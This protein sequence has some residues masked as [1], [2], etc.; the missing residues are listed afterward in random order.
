MSVRALPARPNL[1]HLKNEAK[2]LHKAFNQHASDA[3]RRIADSIGSKETLKLADAQRAIAREY[4]FPTWA[5]LRKHVRLAQPD[6]PAILAFLAA[7]QEQDREGAKRVIAASPE[8]ANESLHVAAALGLA[9]ESKRLLAA[10]PAQISVRTGQPPADPLLYLGY[11]PFHGESA[12]RDAGLLETARVLL[13]A[14]ADPNTR[15]ARYG[16]PVLHAVTGQ[17]SV[18]PIAR[19]LLDA[20]ANPTDGES[21]FH[22]ADHFHEDALALLLDAGVDLN[23]VGDWGNTAPYFLLRWWDVAREPNVKRGLLWLLE[24]GADPNVLSGREQETCLHIAARRGQDVSIIQ[25]LLDRGG[26]LNARRGDRSTAWLLARRAGFDEVA[27]LLENA[28]AETRALSTVDE[29]LS[30]C[31]H[32]D[33]EGARRLASAELIRSLTPADL[34]VLPDSAAAKRWPTVAAC[35]A[36]GFPVNT[37]DG[38]GATAIHYAAINGNVDIVRLL[39]GT[40]PDLSIRDKEHSST[41]LGWG[42]WGS[43]F[44][45][46]P[47]GDYPATI[48]ALGSAGG[49]LGA[50]EHVPQNPDARIAYEESV[51][52]R[53]A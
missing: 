20:G 15:D 49:R 23:Y 37:P 26:G 45:H 53:G 7:C 17:R 36:A 21:V 41:P 3:V 6:R 16:V 9:A 2:A 24:H 4:G 1:D 47:T 31:G 29:L 32:G 42:T 33:V 28:G 52:F 18:L 46:D 44:M 30:A 48:R 10:D 27:T 51:S 11:S 35:I 8:I 12:E 39:L 50:H 13:D 43:D 14:G 22:A 40:G 38:S 25:L 19:M 34:V 5:L